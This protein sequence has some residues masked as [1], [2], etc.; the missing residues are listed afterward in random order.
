MS[1]PR[2]LSSLFAAVQSVAANLSPE[3]LERCAHHDLNPFDAAEHCQTH[4][5][6]LRDYITKELDDRD[7]AGNRK[8]PSSKIED[9]GDVQVIRI[10]DFS[11]I[12]GI[13]ESIMNGRRV[14]AEQAGQV[15]PTNQASE[16][17]SEPVKQPETQVSILER[18]NAELRAEADRLRKAVKLLEL[19]GHLAHE[20]FVQAME[21]A[22]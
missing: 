4:G 21:L 12:P 10:N 14:K 7:R 16:Q 19:G 5:L 3:L 9:F 8:E 15:E 2:K 6:Q 13:I 17:A 11:E 22:A 18:E 1:N 20:R